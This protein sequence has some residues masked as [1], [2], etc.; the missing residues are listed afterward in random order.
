MSYI[1]DDPLFRSLDDAEEE[2]FRDWAREN[3][4][5][6]SPNPDWSLYHPVCREEWVKRGLTVG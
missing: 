5:P 4:P 2:E 6:N 1:T 3:D